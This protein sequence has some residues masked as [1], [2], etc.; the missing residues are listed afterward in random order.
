MSLIQ[1]IKKLSFINKEWQVRI[2]NLFLSFIIAIPF[3][4][5]FYDANL[6]DGI[7]IGLFTFIV[8]PTLYEILKN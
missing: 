8:V 1:K 4:M 5:K 3:E 7:W 2:I 6:I